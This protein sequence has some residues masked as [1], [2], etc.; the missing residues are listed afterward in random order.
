ML[1]FFL[2]ALLFFLVFLSSF[3]YNY[4]FLRALAIKKYE[5]FI[6]V[7]LCCTATAFHL[8]SEL[9]APDRVLVPVP[10]TVRLR[11]SKGVITVGIAGLRDIYGLNHLLYTLLLIL[12]DFKT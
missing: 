12:I 3:I 4:S 8:A 6:V 11:E 2:L 10:S 5:S 7:S 9:F 1:Y